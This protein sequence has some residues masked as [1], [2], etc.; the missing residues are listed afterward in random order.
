[1]SRSS[2]L[3]GVPLFYGTGLAHSSCASPRDCCS[4]RGAFLVA[5]MGV[6]LAML[7]PVA[8]YAQGF[9]VVDV[10]AKVWMGGPSFYVVGV[11]VFVVASVYAAV[12]IPREYFLPPLQ[13]LFR[14]FRPVVFHGF[15]TIPS[16]GL[17]PCHVFVG[18]FSR[19]IMFISCWFSASFA[20][21]T[22]CSFAP[23]FFAAIF[24][25]FRSIEML[26]IRRSAD[27]AF[28]GNP[29]SARWDW[30]TLDCHGCRIANDLRVI[31]KVLKKTDNP[32]PRKVE[33]E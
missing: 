24:G 21:Y 10:K 8:F 26:D 4:A 13:N 19:A 27:R 1:M 18:A 20:I 25:C 9:S 29:F 11:Y 3:A 14:A 28:K 22:G 23:A 32:K 30:Y 7:F 17:F 5:S 12:T 15:P 33:K 6:I 31:K 16:T 2:S